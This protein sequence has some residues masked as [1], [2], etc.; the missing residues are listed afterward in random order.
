MLLLVRKKR[1]N[2]LF[3]EIATSI[4]NS[5]VADLGPK[6]LFSAAALQEP[7]F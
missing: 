7:V 4:N 3:T 5:E 1:E 6:W 2:F